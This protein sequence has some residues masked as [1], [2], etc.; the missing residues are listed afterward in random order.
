QLP[1]REPPRPLE[2]HLLGVFEYARRERRLRRPE[3]TQ[4]PQHDLDG[5]PRH[6]PRQQR[7]PQPR[8]PLELPRDPHQLTTPSRTA[9]TAL[10]HVGAQGR[11]PELVMVAARAQLAEHLP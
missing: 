9:T 2:P 8:P 7:P 10:P 5:A 11:E 4:R 1:H 6:L 3:R